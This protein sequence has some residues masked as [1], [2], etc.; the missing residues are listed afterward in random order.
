[1]PF[2]L[3][4][5]PFAL[6]FMP[7]F[8]LAALALLLYWELVLA[9]GAHLG[10]RVVVGLYD[11]VASRYDRIK[12]FDL[13]TEAELLGWPLTEVLATVEAPRV[14]DVAA[15]TGRVARALLRQIAFDG[16]IANADLSTPM[17]AHGQQACAAWPERVTHLRAPANRLPFADDTFDAVSCLEALEFLPSARAA[18]AECV[19]VLKPGGVLLITNRVGWPAWLMPGKTFSRAAFLRLLAQFPLEAVRVHPW[20]VEYDLAWARKRSLKFEVSQS[21]MCS[22]SNSPIPNCL[23]QNTSI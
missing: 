10:P 15:G 19:R 11:L 7:F 13:D 18:L 23:W 3:H 2:A 9:E 8:L 14:L 21:I 17:L 1:L 16:T 22:F 20:Q 5:L 12:N 6:R 4:P